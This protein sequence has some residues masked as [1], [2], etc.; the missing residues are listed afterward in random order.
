MSQN[1][2]TVNA[3]DRII[4]VYN[5]NFLSEIK[6]IRLLVNDFPYV[7]LDTEFPG[8]LYKSKSSDDI[9]NTI[10]SNVDFLKIIQVGI[11]LF[12]KNGKSPSNSSTWQFN[13]KFDYKTENYSVNSLKMLVNSG[14]NFDLLQRR[15][16]TMEKFGE[17]MI[18]SGLVLNE[19][20]HWISFQGSYDFAYFLKILT[21]KIL[22]DSEDEFFELLDIYFC[23]Y[24]D[25]RYILRNH[26]YYS[27]SLQRIS[28]LLDIPRLGS[29]HQAG[30]DSMLT[31]DIFFRLKK[32]NNCDYKEDMNVLY[33]IGE[34]MDDNHYNY[35]SSL[36][37]DSNFDNLS[38]TEGF[39][40]SKNIFVYGN[41]VN[42]QFNMPAMFPIYNNVCSNI[43][44]T[45][46]Q[47]VQYQAENQVNTNERTSSSTS[48]LDYSTVKKKVMCKNEVS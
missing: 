2:S 39:N 34:G 42:N 35:Y 6:R 24:Y 7:S 23:K 25:I 4:E 40:L 9:Y 17:Y 18:T 31:G 30:S 19:N 13:F 27:L 5:D 43:Y 20:V 11:T 15:G 3:N 22:P 44:Q 1:K 46:I 45:T 16:I 38:Y 28:N 29:Q 37:S 48:L 10:K 12:D 33:G 47:N 26:E 32:I 21:N 8:F 41:N 14:I 36:N